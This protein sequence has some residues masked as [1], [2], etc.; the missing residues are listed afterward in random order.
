MIIMGRSMRCNK[1][2]MLVNVNHSSQFIIRG[3]CITKR[4][5]QNLSMLMQRV[6]NLQHEQAYTVLPSNSKVIVYNGLTFSMYYNRHIRSYHLFYACLH[7]TYNLNIRDMTIIILLCGSN[8]NN[9]L[10]LQY[11]SWYYDTIVYYV[12]DY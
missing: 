11:C 10:A 5:C 9:V 3:F 12:V 1:N 7:S 8:R 2:P 6:Q 4:V